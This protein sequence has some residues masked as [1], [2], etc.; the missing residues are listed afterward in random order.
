MSMTGHISN[1]QHWF[2]G[3]GV[4]DEDGKLKQTLFSILYRA[5]G[6]AIFRAL[7]KRAHTL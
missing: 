7:Y 5:R 1:H 6:S 3:L 2:F 4:F